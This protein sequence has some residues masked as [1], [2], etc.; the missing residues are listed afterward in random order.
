MAAVA[1]QGLKIVTDYTCQD[2][3]NTAMAFAKPNIC[4][5]PFLQALAHHSARKMRQ[6]EAREVSNAL[7]SFTIVGPGVVGPDWLDPALDHFLNLIRMR[8]YEG[9]ELVQV[10]NACWPHRGQ[11]KHW[12]ALERTFK[13]RVFMRV[14]HALEA[15]IGRDQG[16]QGMEEP[17]AEAE[18]TVPMKLLNAGPATH[19]SL[20]AAHRM[21][22]RLS[23][24]ES[25]RRSAQRLIDELQVDFL[26]PIFT[27]VAMRQLGL[28]DPSDC[29]GG[30]AF[31]E[32]TGSEEITNSPEWGV[33]ARSAVA[34][35]LEQMRREL[36]FMWF[37]R[38]GPHERRVISWIAFDLEVAIGSNGLEESSGPWHEHLRETGRITGF[39]LDEHRAM[40][41]RGV[42][43][44]TRLQEQWKGEVLF[45]LH[46]VRKGQEWLQ[47]LFAQHDR[48]GHTER[49]ALLEVIIEII[50]AIR[51]LERRQSQFLHGRAVT[52]PE[53]SIE[54]GLFDGSLGAAVRGQM[55]V[56]VCHFCCISCMAAISNFARRFPHVKMHIDYDDCWRTRLLDV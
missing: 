55:Q 54:L 50:S 47:G 48:A 30:S 2:L 23:P 34:A 6:F 38:F 26:G 22:E 24:L 4:N 25:A 29:R 12:A 32:G 18:I 33:Q 16:L 3:A 19:G 20:S 27:R 44:F 43:T 40:D 31:S 1:E 10:V 41:K 51:R 5:R 17:T 21:P 35:S 28:I 46:D 13:E 9:W 8:Q 15:I 37:D 45:T 49:Q 56:F 11:L 52:Q 7:W 53:T 39:S 42:E 36:P 14:V